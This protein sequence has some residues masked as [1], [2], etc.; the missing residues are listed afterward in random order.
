MTA[1]D[2]IVFFL[3]ASLLLKNE[4]SCCLGAVPAVGGCS[5]ICCRT[6]MCCCFVRMESMLPVEQHLAEVPFSSEASADSLVEKLVQSRRSALANWMLLGW[7]STGVQQGPC[8]A[9]NDH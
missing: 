5:A 3:P 6:V 8:W 1:L 2:A 9:A 4:L 7:S